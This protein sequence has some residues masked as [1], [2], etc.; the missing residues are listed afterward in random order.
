V[1]P[2]VV[3][4]QKAPPATSRPI[5]PA[6]RCSP[7]SPQ[8]PD[9]IAQHATHV[10]KGA[11]DP[12]TDAKGKVGVYA[13][14]KSPEATVVS[15]NGTTVRPDGATYHVTPSLDLSAGASEKALADG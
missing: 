1:A 12:P 3:V 6:P 4:I 14:D 8:F 10:L 5:K 15:V 7:N 9:V 11:I 2:A 13:L